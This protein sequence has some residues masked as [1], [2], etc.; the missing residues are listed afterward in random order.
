[1]GEALLRARAR[2]R[3]AVGATAVAAVVSLASTGVM[4]STACATHACDGSLVDE[5]QLDPSGR[6]LVGKMIDD[7]TWESNGLDEPWLEFPA[8]RAYIFHTPLLVGRVPLEMLAYVSTVDNPNAGPDN[9]ALASG[10]LA[11]FLNNHGDYF[12]VK[13]DTCGQYFVR[14]VVRV[15]HA[16]AD[17]GAP[18]LDGASDSSDAIANDAVA[19]DARD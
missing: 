8:Q 17:A 16:S 6:Y 11:E 19:N 5:N 9:Y 14:V 13:N 10:N 4:S 15:A 3:G 18:I 1:M 7:D 12:L 2:V